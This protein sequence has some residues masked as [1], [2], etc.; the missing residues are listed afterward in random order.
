MEQDK[1]TI[2]DRIEEILISVMLGVA[3]LLVFA[4][5]VARYVFNAGITWAPE[6]VQHLFLWTVMIGASYG[7]KHGVHLGVDV[8]MKKLPETQRRIMALF[9]VVIS[10][11]FTGYM[12]YLSFF[13]VHDAYKMDLITV[14]LQI[15]Q[16]IPHLALPFGFTM[17][18]IRLIQVFWWI[19]TG[20][21]VNVST[22]GELDADDIEE[23]P[24]ISPSGHPNEE[25]DHLDLIKE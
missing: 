3:T 14:D 21:M 7:F 6:L 25:D 8:L 18:S 20:R 2:I 13:Y 12:A 23:I 16:W 17:I 22:S 1:P 5:V 24:D 15:P 10:F 19:Y 9:A 11:G 4:Q